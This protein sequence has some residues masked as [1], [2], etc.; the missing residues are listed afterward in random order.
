M[1]TYTNEYNKTHCCCSASFTI[2]VLSKAVNSHTASSLSTQGPVV[3]SMVG[4]NQRLS[5]IKINRLSWY[6]TL[7]RANQA[8]NN[9]AQVCKWAQHVNL[10]DLV[11]PMTEFL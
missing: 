1:I 8:S 4:A 3:R 11:L 9:S 7:V 5:S 6:L 2:H 10:T